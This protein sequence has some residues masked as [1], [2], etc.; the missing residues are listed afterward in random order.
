LAQA[1]GLLV[2]LDPAE[3][4]G[5]LNTMFY[6]DATNCRAYGR[7]LGNRYK[8]CTNVLWM[9]GN[10]FQDWRDP[11]SDAIAREIALGIQET[12]TNHLQTLALDYFVSSSLDDT[13]W[14]SIIGLN[15][16]YTYYATY[17]ELYKD[18][19]RTNPLPTFM[20]EANYEYE[21]AW[22]GNITLR[23]Q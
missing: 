8:S 20:A 14:Y 6:N 3:T 7:F 10:D 17:A 2:I 22:G 21:H 9:S 5:W 18:Y 12:D 16:A 4:G 15:A 11:A 19:N 23:R 1:H 13:N